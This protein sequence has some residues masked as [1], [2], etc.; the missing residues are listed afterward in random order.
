M[1]LSNGRAVVIMSAAT[2]ETINEHL[3]EV[4]TRVAS[5][6]HAVLVCDGAG[7]QQRG[8][9]LNVPDNITLP[10]PYS[11]ELFPR[12]NVWGYLRGHK[13]SHRVWASHGAIIDACAKAWQFL[14]DD[15]DQIW[16]IVH[17]DWA[18]VNG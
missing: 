7:W 15:P 12:E 16:S 9:G 2:S 1:R 18:W 14:I 11:P 17:R 4:S 10:P 3:K 6:T 5:G 8:K 13:L